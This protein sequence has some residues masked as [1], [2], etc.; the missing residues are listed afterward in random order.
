[1]Y[2]RI[3]CCNFSLSFH[4]V[5]TVVVCSFCEC[6]LEQCIGVFVGIGV[7]ERERKGK[8]KGCLICDVLS[9]IHDLWL[10]STRCRPYFGH[11]L[12][13]SNY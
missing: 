3:A 11:E 7:K 12:G 8:R 13:M 1:M 5:V 4:D 10:D 6:M 2:D 9:V